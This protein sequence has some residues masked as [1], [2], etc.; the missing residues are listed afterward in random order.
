MLS[1]VVVV[2]LLSCLLFCCGTTSYCLGFLLWYCFVVVVFPVVLLCGVTTLLCG[3]WLFYFVVLLLYPL[4]LCGVTSL[5]PCFIL[6]AFVVL[7]RA[8]GFRC[9]VTAFCLWCYFVLSRCSVVVLLFYI[10]VLCCVTSLAYL[11]HYGF[12]WVVLGCCLGF[13]S[14]LVVVLSGLFPCCCLWCYW[15]A[16]G[17]VMLGLSACFLRVSCG[18]VWVVLGCCLSGV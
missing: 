4:I 5:Y 2:L 10:W 8:I 18:G 3:V 17:D 6:L 9:G 16:V 13:I 1:C 15:V 14:G 7:L 12:V 11:W